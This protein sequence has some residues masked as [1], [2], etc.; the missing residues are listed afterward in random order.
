MK[1]VTFPKPVVIVEK[2]VTAGELIED[3]VLVR[4]AWRIGDGSKHA[5]IVFSALDKANGK[6]KLPD[7]T[8]NFLLEQMQL[9]PGTNISPRAA[10]RFYLALMRAFNDADEVDEVK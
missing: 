7:K 2:E 6:L 1:E 4:Q 3:L 9:D 8:F 10:N 5:D